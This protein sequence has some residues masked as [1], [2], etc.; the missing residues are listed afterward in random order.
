MSAERLAK[1]D[2][3]IERGIKAGGYPGA[4][5]VVGRRGAAVWE[6]GFG[7]QNVA[8][9]LR[10]TI[11]PFILRRTKAEVARDLPEKIETDNFCELTG[12]QAA[13]YQAVLK[14]VRAQVMGEVEKHPHNVARGTFM[15]RDGVLQPG[16][17]PRFSRTKAEMGPPGRPRGADSEAV[18][19]DWGFAAADIAKLAKAGIVGAA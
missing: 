2:H 12:E 3:V 6:K 11:H 9:R 7:F 1:I 8:T 14:E 13:L 17:A 16:P 18:L 10:A 15:R 5:V 4:S 19:A